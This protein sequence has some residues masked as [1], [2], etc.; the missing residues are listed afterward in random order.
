M[1][2]A[3]PSPGTG[4]S[5]KCNS[6]PTTKQSTGLYP[7]DPALPYPPEARRARLA[8]FKEKPEVLKKAGIQAHKYE[9][10][11]D[12]A[13]SRKRVNGKFVK[14][15]EEDRDLAPQKRQRTK[16]RRQH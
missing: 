4:T 14:K 11:T 12:F 7:R 2:A 10:R 16:K 9:K 3:C 13:N 5:K 15:E 8:W 1:E 6:P